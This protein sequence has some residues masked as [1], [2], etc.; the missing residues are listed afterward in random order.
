VCVCVQ[1]D[2]YS[3]VANF[4]GD[5]MPAYVFVAG[6]LYQCLHMCVCACVCVQGDKNS[7][8]AKFFG[9]STPAYVFL[10]V[11]FW[12]AVINMEGCLMVL[13]SNFIGRE[14]R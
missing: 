9:G 8:V 10:I 3:H 11:F 7:H 6:V 4:F 14:N 2:E 12:S 5:S 1:G 13:V